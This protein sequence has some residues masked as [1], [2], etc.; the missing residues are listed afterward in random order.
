M[1]LSANSKP[2]FTTI[3]KF[4]FTMDK[5]VVRLLWKCYWSVS[6]RIQSVKKWSRLTGTNNQAPQQN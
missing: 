5:E 4:I 1:A 6:R 2:H 3:A